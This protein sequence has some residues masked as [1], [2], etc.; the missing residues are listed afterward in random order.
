MFDNIAVAAKLILTKARTES[1]ESHH[2]TRLLIEP[3]LS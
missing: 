3:N 2:L 1:N